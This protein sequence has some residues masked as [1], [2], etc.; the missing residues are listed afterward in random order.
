M[1]QQEDALA[2]AVQKLERAKEKY[3]RLAKILIGVKAGIDHL[4]DKLSSVRK[5]EAEAV[6]GTLESVPV[7][8]AV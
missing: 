8:R 6:V 5:G 1:D 4:T 3:D 2:E 7:W